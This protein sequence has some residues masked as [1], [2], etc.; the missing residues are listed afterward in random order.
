MRVMGMFVAVEEGDRF[1]DQAEA[2]GMAQLAVVGRRQDRESDA[3][4]QQ[5]RQ[6]LRHQERVCYSR[7][8]I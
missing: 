7:P 2:L 4:R 3:E 8:S 5:Q 1:R 6:H